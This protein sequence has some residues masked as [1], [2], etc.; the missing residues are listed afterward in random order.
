MSLFDSGIV[1][2][3]YFFKPTFTQFDSHIPVPKLIFLKSRF[4]GSSF[5]KSSN[6]P[7]KRS[8]NRLGF[9]L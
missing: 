6:A 5:R 3:E 9:Y 7:F 2:Q 1:Q 4:H 8:S